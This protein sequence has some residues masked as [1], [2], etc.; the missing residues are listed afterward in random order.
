MCVCVCVSESGCVL[1][2]TCASGGSNCPLLTQEDRPSEV[3]LGGVGLPPL[4]PNAG[5]CLWPAP[6][7]CE[8][9]LHTKAPGESRLALRSPGSQGPARLTWKPHGGRRGEGGGSMDAQLPPSWRGQSVVWSRIR[10][11][12]A[13]SGDGGDEDDGWQWRRG[14]G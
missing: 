5:A 11:E 13:D 10:L 12:E 4:L 9:S 14:W 6:P 3:E 2:R 7:S 1:E 8:A